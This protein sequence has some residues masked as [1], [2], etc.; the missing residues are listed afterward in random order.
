MSKKAKISTGIVLGLGLTT[1][2]VNICRFFIIESSITTV[3]APYHFY[4]MVLLS[5]LEI[6]IGITAASLATIRPLLWR[7]SKSFGDF[8]NYRRSAQQNRTRSDVE[9]SIS[10]TSINFGK[11][12]TI[13]YRMDRDHSEEDT[14]TTAMTGTRIEQSDIEEWAAL[15]SATHI[16]AANETEALKKACVKRNS[17]SG[18]YEDGTSDMYQVFS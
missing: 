4:P 17:V 9:T 12:S 3:N 11:G 16:R 10:T 14:H 2:I 18:S 6:G 1:G 5:T 15:C 7:I 8:K 13:P